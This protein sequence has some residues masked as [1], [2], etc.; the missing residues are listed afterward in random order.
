M[1]NF[2]VIKNQST[3]SD[4]SV[5]IQN[6]KFLI[7]M[8]V[9]AKHVPNAYPVNFEFNCQYNL[10]TKEGQELLFNEIKEKHYI[11]WALLSFMELKI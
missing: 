7:S 9:E 2:N 8:L 11:S 10:D 4:G 3:N 6:K 5:E 1:D